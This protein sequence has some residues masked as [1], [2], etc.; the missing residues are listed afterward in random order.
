[1]RRPEG[2]WRGIFLLP[3]V[4]R[5][6][7]SELGGVTW[8]DVWLSS[9]SSCVRCR[10]HSPDTRRGSVSEIGACEHASIC[11]SVSIVASPSRF[12]FT[13]LRVAADSVIAATP[14]G[15]LRPPHVR[16]VGWFSTPKL[17]V[18]QRTALL[19]RPRVN[20]VGVVRLLSP[21][22][23][24][25]VDAR[26]REIETPASISPYH[27]P[28]REQRPANYSHVFECPCVK[29]RLRNRVFS[30]E[31]SVKISADARL[32]LALKLCLYVP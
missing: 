17:L 7:W 24:D 9:S 25:A 21:T 27:Y 2:G 3:A 10:L 14:S 20:R 19:R 15:D 13:D 22:V 16:R 26:P 29:S 6:A 32:C 8:S 5:R 28:R 4:N 1:M 31:S 12:S 23:T 30:R 11:G 18:T